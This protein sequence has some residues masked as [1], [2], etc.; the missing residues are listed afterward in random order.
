MC[1]IDSVLAQHVET[2]DGVYGSSRGQQGGH[3]IILQDRSRQGDKARAICTR[4]L[5]TETTVAKSGDDQT[6]QYILH[7]TC[8]FVIAERYLAAML[9]RRDEAQQGA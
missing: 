6:K 9:P 4:Y 3:H 8:Q 5:T 7:C 2:G 1:A